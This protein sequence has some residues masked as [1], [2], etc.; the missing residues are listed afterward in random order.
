MPRT[1]NYPKSMIIPHMEPIPALA[2][3]S[4]KKIPAM[5]IGKSIRHVGS[6]EG[7]YVFALAG[8][9]AE[10]DVTGVNG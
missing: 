5:S 9:L 3:A 8:P 7:F 6:L 2:D 1:P 10:K 4:G